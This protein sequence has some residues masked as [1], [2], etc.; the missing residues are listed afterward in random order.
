MST[1]SV[2]MQQVDNSVQELQAITQNIVRLITDLENE[3]ERSLTEWEGSVQQTYRQKK[4]QWDAAAAEMSAA[5]NKASQSLGQINTS[6]STTEQ[7]GTS[8]WG[9]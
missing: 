3:S 4:V 2:Q 7:K 9:S 8:M 5:A 6:Y 1:Y